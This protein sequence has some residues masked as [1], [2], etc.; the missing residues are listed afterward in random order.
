LPREEKDKKYLSSRSFR[1]QFCHQR[2]HKSR[3]GDFDLKQTKK[4]KLY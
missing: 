3:I 4:K 2:T 1:F